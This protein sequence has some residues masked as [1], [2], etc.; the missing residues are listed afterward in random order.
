MDES[1]TAQREML[2]NAAKTMG[3]ALIWSA[4]EDLSPRVEGSRLVFNPHLSDG[5]AYRLLVANNIILSFADGAPS[6]AIA[7]LGSL[8][9]VENIADH[10]DKGAAGRAAILWIAAERGK[11]ILV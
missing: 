9:R 1:K 11:S 3:L 6:F 2:H 4:E 8:R 10:T 7:E 5:A